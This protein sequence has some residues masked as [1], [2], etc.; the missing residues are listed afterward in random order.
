M[1]KLMRIYH[2]RPPLGKP[3]TP[4]VQIGI[5]AKP[6]EASYWGRGRLGAG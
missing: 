4:S 1:P 6:I 5:L 2:R 3:P